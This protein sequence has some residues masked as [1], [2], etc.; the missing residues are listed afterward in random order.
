MEGI[1]SIIRALESFPSRATILYDSAKNNIVTFKDVVDCIRKLQSENERL[2]DIE[3]TKKHCD[4]YSENE[5]LHNALREKNEE[6]ERL[7]R[8][9]NSISL[10]VDLHAE[11][12]KQ[13]IEDL[14][15]AN[16]ELQQQVEE[17]KEE[18]KN[19]DWYKMWHKKFKIEIEDLTLEL[20]TYRPTKLSGNGQCKCS[21][22]GN[23]SWTDFGFSKYKGKILCNKC[24]KEITQT[25]KQHTVKDTAKEILQYME[26][27]KVE[28]DG[29][30]QWRDEHNRCIERISCKIQQKFIN[31][32]EVE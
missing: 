1:E 26:T 25:E 13:E 14:E 22:C 11:S 5:F 10:G 12:Y 31:N 30:H 4:L 23:V 9:N 24:L 6:I 8:L 27:L 16:A 3:F 18:L 7:T 20:E 19:L 29:R 28:E 17:L 21:D 2:N 15:K 32:V